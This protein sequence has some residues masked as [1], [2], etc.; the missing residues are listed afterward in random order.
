MNMIVSG[1][2]QTRCYYRVATL[3]NKLITVRATLKNIPQGWAQWDHILFNNIL[4]THKIVF[5]FIQIQQISFPTS[6]TDLVSN[7][8]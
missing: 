6:V 8:F 5:V 2:K 7:V 4:Q 3:L 1:Y